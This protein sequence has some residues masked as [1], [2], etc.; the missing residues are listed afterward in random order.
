MEKI[1]ST[2]QERGLDVDTPAQ[3]ALVEEIIDS[4]STAALL[5]GAL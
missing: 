1:V 2:V 4:S 3:I 5:S